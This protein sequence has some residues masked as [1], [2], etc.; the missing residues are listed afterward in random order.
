MSKAD[1]SAWASAPPSWITRPSNDFDGIVLSSRVRI[2]RN[3]LGVPFPHHATLAQQKKSLENMLEVLKSSSVMHKNSSFRLGQ[4]SSLERMFLMERQLISHEHAGKE[5][6]GGLVV[7]AGESISVMINEEDH[8]RAACFLPGLGLSEAWEILTQ[9]DD[10]IGGKLP[11][12]YNAELGYITACP[13]NMGTG[14]RASCLLHLPGLVMTGKIQ[15]VV[16]ELSHAGLTARGFYGEGTTALGDLFQISN[17]R[18]LGQTENQIIKDVEGTVREICAYEKRQRQ[19]IQDAE[20]SVLFKD[21]ITRSYGTIRWAK[22]LSLV[23]GMKNVSM[24]R[25]GLKLG[26]DLP[27]TIDKATSLFFMSQPAHLK[28]KAPRGRSGESDDVLR[29]EY[30]TSELAKS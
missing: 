24:A 7:S 29:A 1:F 20:D 11:L 12:S 28:M 5:G 14:L 6:E 8:V 17:V 16:N 15:S 22:V 21:Q 23:E 3:F 25:L 9:L 27:L 2:A 19:N 4:L 10:E 18:T 13:T 26:I 30:F